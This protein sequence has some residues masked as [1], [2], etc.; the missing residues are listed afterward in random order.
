MLLLLACGPTVHALDQEANETSSGHDDGA[1]SIDPVTTGAATTDSTPTTTPTTASST[2]TTGPDD[3]LDDDP[4][5]GFIDHSDFPVH[6]CDIFEQAC[7]DGLKC[8]P[9]AYDEDG[10]PHGST[11]VAIEA[12]PNHVGEACTLYDAYGGADDCDASSLCWG[13]D[14]ETLEG[15]CV[16]L[17]TYG[18]DAP[19]C[20]D[21]TS[22]CMIMADGL[23]PLCLSCCDPLASHCE[24]G[25]TCLRLAEG[26]A[27]A[28]TMESG[29][30]LGDACTTTTR[31]E[32]GLHCAAAALLPGCQG[33]DGC[34]TPYCDLGDANACDDGLACT[35]VFEPAPGASCATQSVGACLPVP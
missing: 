13:L 10:M 28:P 26:F 31:C 27:C 5:G 23:L 18:D 33:G 15:T 30:P 35:P 32:P 7:L 25:T 8:A 34:C 16:A 17:C 19:V 6:G 22:S 24:E 21:E 14:P 3:G 1:G 4:S 20:A 29:A 12:D 2:S 9:I 11:C